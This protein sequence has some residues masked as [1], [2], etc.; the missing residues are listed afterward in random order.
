[1]RLVLG[2]EPHFQIMRRVSAILL[3]TTPFWCGLS[4]LLAACAFGSTGSHPAYGEITS[5]DFFPILPWDPYHGWSK[6]FREHPQNGLESV[7]DCNFNLAGFVHPRDLRRCEKLHLGAI[8]VPD[9][10]DTTS[11]SYA[12]EWK[13]MS[14]EAIER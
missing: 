6:P 8:V 3:R 10:D 4:L 2:P 11:P 14:D 12:R 5:S 9:D 1:M 13:K 7:A